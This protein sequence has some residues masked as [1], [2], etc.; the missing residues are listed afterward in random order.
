MNYNKFSAGD[1]ESLTTVAMIEYYLDQGIR[2]F[3][4]QRAKRDEIQM[5]VHA[6]G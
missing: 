5:P 3:S 6:K 2:A 1:D 4:N